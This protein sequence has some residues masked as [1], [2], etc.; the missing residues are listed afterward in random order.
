MTDMNPPSASEVVANLLNTL[1]IARVVF[2]DDLNTDSIALEDVIAAARVLDRAKLREILPEFGE[3]IADDEDVLTSRLRTWW[4]GHEPDIRAERSRAILDAVRQGDRDYINDM[5]AISVFDTIIPRDKLISLSPEQWESQKGKLLKENKDERTVFLFDRIFSSS[6]GDSQG[7]IKI[8]SWLLMQ[9]DAENLICG[10][11]TH[12][13]TPETQPQQWIEL[14]NTYGLPRDRFIVIPKSYL[15]INPLFFAQTLKYAALS[16]DFAEMKRMTKDII[17]AATTAAAERVEKV[18]IYDLDHIVFRVSADE[19]QWEPD[20]LFRLH[21]MFHRTEARRLAHAGAGL[22]SVAAKLRK[23]SGVSTGPNLLPAPTSAWDLQREE[24]YDQS[25]HIN[26]NHLPLELGDIFERTDGVSNKK[27]ILLAQPCDLM[28][29]SKGER[30]PVLDRVPLVEVAMADKPSRYS[31]EMP[32]FDASPSKRWFVKLKLVHFVRVG[33]LDLCVFNQN[34]TAKLTLG[35]DVPSGIRPA[36]KAR[37]GTL[38][39]NWDKVVKKADLLAEVETDD[40]KTKQVK[41]EISKKLGNLLFDDDFFKG[42]IVVEG[43]A[44]SVQYDLRR[45][46]RL[47]RTRAIGL[48]MSYTSTL[49][50]PAYD[51]EFGP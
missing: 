44:R 40:P 38:S 33:V 43:E 21:T 19:G 30:E 24:L 15:T 51:L 41:S 26:G 17:A 1:G 6:G 20:M 22:E 4:D 48:L 29:R 11:L 31:E 37:Y 36:W 32:Y 35:E 12:T 23:V 18:S 46:G 39:R 8:I 45:W 47:S 2:V 42:R 14:S 7:G 34:G 27:Y 10:L 9:P 5:A 3:S 49:G 25:D 13:V 16:P 50:R 28:V